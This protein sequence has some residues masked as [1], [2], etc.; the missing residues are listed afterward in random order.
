MNN[1]LID[2]T[3]YRECATRACDQLVPEGLHTGAPESQGLKS[4]RELAAFTYTCRRCQDAPCV[5]VCQEEALKK[6]AEIDYR[7]HSD[8]T[9]LPS[10]EVKA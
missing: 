8:V 7:L 4:I 2:L 1:I 5:S 3:K 9:R 6:K 10:K